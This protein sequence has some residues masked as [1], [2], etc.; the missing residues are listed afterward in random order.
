MLAVMLPFGCAAAG[1]LGC[2]RADDISV[3]NHTSYASRAASSKSS[4][5]AVTGRSDSSSAGRYSD[6]SSDPDTES[7]ETNCNSG[8]SSETG[9]FDYILFGLLGVGGI[10]FL[11]M[12]IIGLASPDEDK[13]KL[14]AAAQQKK[15]QELQGQT[16]EEII[17]QIREHDPGFDPQNFISW[18]KRVFI[19]LQQAWQER[20][21]KKAR[22]FESE[23]LFNQHKT[24]LDEYINNHTINIMKD[25]CVGEA[26][27]CE[28]A[29]EGSYEY[30]TVFMQTGYFDYIID[31]NTKEVVK[32][33]P[34]TYY[35][36]KYL[37]KF[38][39]TLGV[40]TGEYSNES[41]TKCPNCGA[42]VDVNAAG[43]CSYC[44]TV[45]TNGDHD[46][47]LCNLDDIRQ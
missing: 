36:V 21:W 40:V 20:D 19:Q 25:V 5:W 17:A 46:W 2:V 14:E 29:A 11:I 7:S 32:G 3:G 24:E 47:V 33:N 23:E 22:P 30:L 37:A 27:L 41:T 12:L 44:G 16:E 6:S 34:Q 43:E 26:H 35:A 28:Y 9:I 18:S 31:E 13:S 38:K 15:E 10:I 45:I 39:R 8:S 42:P 4:T 1:A